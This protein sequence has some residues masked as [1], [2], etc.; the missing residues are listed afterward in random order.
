VSI[1][2]EQYRRQ[3]HSGFKRAPIIIR[4]AYARCVQLETQVEKAQAVYAGERVRFQAGDSTVLLVTKMER[5]LT[6]AKL[7]LVDAQVEYQLGTLVLRV[8]TCQI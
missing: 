1:E 8:I 2:I 4:F 3:C 6:E 7:E 5:Q